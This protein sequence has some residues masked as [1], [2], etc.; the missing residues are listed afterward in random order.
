[1]TQ[2]S[3]QRLI[4]GSPY[5]TARRHRRLS[6]FLLPALAAIAAIIMVSCAS[7]STPTATPQATLTAPSAPPGAVHQATQTPLPA[8]AQ[9]TGS[10]VVYS[11]RAESLVSPIIKQFEGASGIKV[12]V[13]Y[14]GTPQLAATLLE[15][16]ARSPADLFYAQDPGGLAAV[17][18]MFAALPESIRSLVPRW[19]QSEQ[20][21]WVGITARARTLVYNSKKLTAEELP[22]DIWDLQGP[23]WRG[24]IGWAPTNASLQTMVTAMQV[25]WG[26]QK[27]KQWLQGILANEPRTYQGNSQQV[28]A[29]ADG[30][31]D[32]GLVNHYYLYRFI[33]ER[34]ESFPAANYHPRAGGPGALVMVSGAGILSTAKNRANAERFL[35]F[36][37]STVAQQYFAGTTY[38]YPLVKGVRSHRSLVPEED[39]KVPNV[40]MSQLADLAGSLRLMREA[41][42]LK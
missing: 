4:Q 20:G 26:E 40:T 11:G 2:P 17:E 1:M 28:Q 32:V 6:G 38:E 33:A 10:L 14:A 15:E 30:E 42:V 41:G 5:G 31:I 9:G 22:D 8:A 7:S 16:G 23:K 27:T 37:L 18:S 36:M 13:K 34:S 24:R 25:L 35:Q 3:R 29:V 21:K 39:I 12:E 19:A